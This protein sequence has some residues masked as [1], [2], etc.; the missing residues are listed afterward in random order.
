[1]SDF[2]AIETQEEFDNA[3]KDRIERNTRSV[4][5]EVEKK[6]EGFISPDDFTKKSSDLTKQID[7]LN[8]KLE[9]NRT[10]ISDLTAKNKAYEIT[11][12]KTK[13]AH[14]YNIPFEMADRL[15]GESEEDIKKDAEK[16]SKFVSGTHFSPK[17]N[18]EVPPS[19][20]KTAA[21]KSMLQNLK[22]E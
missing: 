7:E 5:A 19:D 6:F 2:T 17:F 21:Y 3:I 11:L 20:S 14:E 18:S 1:M 10:S 8:G 12:V 16:I 22:G 9:A 13:I 4:T 15:S